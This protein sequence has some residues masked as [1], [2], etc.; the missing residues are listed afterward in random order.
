MTQ[1]ALCNKFK[2]VCLSSFSKINAK[3][4]RWNYES[5]GVHLLPQERLRYLSF[6]SELLGLFAV[7]LQQIRGKALRR[8][9]KNVFKCVLLESFRGNQTNPKLQTSGEIEILSW[10]FGRRA[11]TLQLLL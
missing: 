7:L 1:L 8:C 5:Y 6:L 11:L 2:F 9:I 10:M 4:F 3:C